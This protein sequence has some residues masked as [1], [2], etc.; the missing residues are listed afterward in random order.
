MAT[1]LSA[2]LRRLESAAKG[3]AV[4]PVRLLVLPAGVEAATPEADRLAAEHRERTR[5][6]AVVVLSASD[7]AL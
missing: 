7:V 2:R 6:A 3:D 1:T 5:C 4:A